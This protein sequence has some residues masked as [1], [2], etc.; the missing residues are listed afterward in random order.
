MEIKKLKTESLAS[1][2]I[3]VMTVFTEQRKCD[4]IF[5]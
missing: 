1:L 5:K 3:S 2:I 4:G